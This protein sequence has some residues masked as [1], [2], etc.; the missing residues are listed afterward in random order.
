M[1]D[2]IEKQVYKFRPDWLNNKN[3]TDDK[4]ESDEEYVMK[5]P[6]RTIELIKFYGIKW[7]NKK[8]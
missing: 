3:L 2:D 7:G 8:V 1:N 6:P 4:K 5:L